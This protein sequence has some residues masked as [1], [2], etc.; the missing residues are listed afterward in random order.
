MRVRLTVFDEVVFRQTLQA[1]GAREALR[2]YEADGGGKPVPLFRRP[3]VDVLQKRRERV[4]LEWL[5][6]ILVSSRAMMSRAAQHRG[7]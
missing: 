6:E 3:L 2:E 4:V 7:G 1:G 5:L